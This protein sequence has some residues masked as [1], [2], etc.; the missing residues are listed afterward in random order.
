MTLPASALNASTSEEPS[1]AH[2]LVLSTADWDSPLWTNK[3]YLA[4][5][6]AREFRVTYLESVGLRRVT[7]SKADALRIARR[8]QRGVAA[9]VDVH[10]HRPRP[11][12]MSV[13]SP[14]VLPAHNMRLARIVNPVLIKRGLG[15]WRRSPQR[16]LWTFSPVT[17][18]LEEFAEA[19]IY[20]AVDLL[21]EYPGHYR[22]EVLQGERDLATGECR[23]VASSRAV[24]EHLLDVGFPTPDLW[25]NVAD[26]GSFA[27]AARDSRPDGHVLFAGNLSPHKVDFELLARVA[28]LPGCTLHIAGPHAIDGTGASQLPDL[29]AAGAVLHGSLAP[30]ELARLVGSC[31]VGIIPYKSNPYTAGVFPM[32]LYEYLGAGAAVVATALPAIAN[33]V[34]QDVVICDSADG[35]LDA[36]SRRLGSPDRATVARR[37]AAAADHSWDVRGE[38]ARSLVRDS[39]GRSSG[40]DQRACRERISVA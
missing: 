6:L 27:S 2:V 18:G 11:E 5:E 9:K 21:H 17:Y 22:E 13:V 29:Q 15:D 37:Q 7:A 33:S 28:Q 26:V 35:F 16:L 3:Q 25:E 36:V 30:Q 10:G 40:S 12:S 32:K 14:L 4:L 8:F 34:S 1:A 19:T 20:H 31:S 24:M 23:A 39:L 38:Q